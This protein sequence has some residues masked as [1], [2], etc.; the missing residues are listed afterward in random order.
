MA[1]QT[2]TRLELPSRDEAATRLAALDYGARYRVKTATHRR[3]VL[4]EPVL[5]AA[6]VAAARR[7]RHR[8]RWLA[9]AIG[10][11]AV[12]GMIAAVVAGALTWWQALLLVLLLAAAMGIRIAVTAIL[13]RKSEQ[14]HAEVL[15]EAGSVP[16]AG[17]SMDLE[18]AHIGR[19]RASRR[20]LAASIVVLAMVAAIAWVSWQDQ[21]IA[22]RLDQR[23]DV[24]QAR[25]VDTQ[26]HR[27][28]AAL[29]LSDRHVVTFQT[30][31][32]RAVEAT[33]I[34]EEELSI[35]DGD[36]VEVRYDPR[37][38]TVARLAGDT[39]GR[40]EHLWIGLSIAGLLML[41][42]GVSQWRLRRASRSSTSAP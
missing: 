7:E 15:E 18:G 4:E 16:P 28:L 37:D 3:D 22:A 39:D 29:L 35:Q 34:K 30:R 2:P 6:V 14:R 20:V 13:I 12:V 5:A 11:A 32:G 26:S 38:P 1:T 42:I 24:A 8:L 33:V 41:V 17:P 23:G 25:V 27:K 10:V 40:T 31:D 9:A 36:I 19:T 21:Q